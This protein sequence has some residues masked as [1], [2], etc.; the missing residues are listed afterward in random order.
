MKEPIKAN[1]NLYCYQCKKIVTS[2]SDHC[3]I[4]KKKAKVLGHSIKIGTSNGKY[5]MHI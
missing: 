3:P 2:I 1:F 5:D 4:C